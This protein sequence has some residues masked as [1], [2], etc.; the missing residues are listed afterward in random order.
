MPAGKCGW[1]TFPQ[2]RKWEKPDEFQALLIWPSR[3]RLY[4]MKNFWVHCGKGS[5]PKAFEALK[6]LGGFCENEN[7]KTDM[8]RC[9][10]QLPSLRE[11]RFY[12]WMLVM[13]HNLSHGYIFSNYSSFLTWLQEI[14]DI[15]RELEYSIKNQ[16]RA[17]QSCSYGSH[18]GDGI[19]LHSL[20]PALTQKS[21]V[22]ASW[23]VPSPRRCCPQGLL[24]KRFRRVWA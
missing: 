4:R 21:V 2:E 22:H 13:L 8:Q 18:K 14:L 6:S 19:H 17:G 12:L 24:V 9:A 16:W 23:A 20:S 3:S 5:S 10:C 15:F 1:E 7:I 11:G